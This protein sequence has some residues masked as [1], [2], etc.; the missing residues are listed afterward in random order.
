MR[1][2]NV[3]EFGKVRTEGTQRHRVVKC[4]KVL[5]DHQILSSY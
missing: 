4:Q 3:N 2:L 5:G 1:S